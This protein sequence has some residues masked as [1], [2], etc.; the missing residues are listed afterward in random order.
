MST[1]FF[2]SVLKIALILTSSFFTDS[3][4]TNFKFQVLESE[5]SYENPYSEE[6]EENP[7]L[8]IDK[9][10]LPDQKEN[11]NFLIDDEDYKDD[12][13]DDD[14]NG[15]GN[16]SQIDD[17]QRTEE[18]E[19]YEGDNHK[20]I[21]EEQ[22]QIREEKEFQDTATISYGTPQI[23]LTPQEEVEGEGEGV[24]EREEKEEGKE[25]KENENKEHTT[26]VPHNT[27]KMNPSGKPSFSLDQNVTIPSHSLTVGNFSQPTKKPS[28]NIPLNAETATTEGD[29]PPED[30]PAFVAAEPITQEVLDRIAEDME[31]RFE[32]LEDIRKAKVALRNQGMKAID[33]NRW[34]VHFC[35]TTGMEHA[36]LVRR[37]EGYVLPNQTSIKLTHFNGCAY[38]LEPT[39]DFK[40]ILPGNSLEFW[41]NIGP[42]IARSDLGPRWYVAAE[43]L[44]PRV[45]SN[46]AD[47]SL[48]FVF[49]SKR[50]R[51]W[52]RFGHNDV[53][54]LGTAPLLVIPTP[55][56][57]LGLNVSRKIHI[58]SEWVVVG[59]LGLENEAK[60][61]A[62][63]TRFYCLTSVLSLV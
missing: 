6:T 15:D 12:N 34:S 25:K 48:D 4:S 46:T 44:Q 22:Q 57:I 31:V 16:D 42:T 49:L 20:E 14:K 61:V 30:K 37:P 63:D 1:C 19:Y 38:K 50:K 10:P 33:G 21:K 24:E 23:K 35:V 43:G 36:H 3:D 2:V 58:D 40:P 11:E 8:S 59:E 56:E 28:I 51:S 29:K 26:S 18:N 17:D 5:K 39:K 55:L 32:V 52:D 62:G 7:V 45:I 9:I 47:E 13:E 27:Q 53:E 60:F 41:V 54:D